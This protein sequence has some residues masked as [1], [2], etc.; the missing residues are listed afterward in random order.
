MAYGHNLPWRSAIRLGLRPH[1]PRQLPVAA[2]C[3]SS[4]ISLPQIS[5]ASTTTPRYCSLDTRILELR[6]GFAT[7]PLRLK[8]ERPPGEE[9][10]DIVEEEVDEEAKRKE[11]EEGEK[12]KKKKEK[13]EEKDGE[14]KVE[15]GKREGIPLPADVLKGAASSASGG[16]RSGNGGSKSSS[17][18][19]LLKPTVPDVYPQ[20]MALPIAGRPLFPGFYKAITIRDPKATAAIQEMLKRGQPYV[21]AFLFKDEEANADTISSTD[22]VYEIGVF[23]QVTSVFPV[24]GEEGAINAVLYP[25]RRIRL[26]GLHAQDAEDAE[27]P[28]EGVPDAP[29]PIPESYIEEI[30]EEYQE[31]KDKGD[32]VA[33]FEEPTEIE[34]PVKPISGGY[35]TGF[36]KKFGVSIV[37][38]ENVADEPFD[39][40]DPV[41]RAVTAEIVSVFKDV[42]NMNPLFRDQISNFSISQ[43]SGNVIDEPAKLADF[44]AAVAAG[45]VAEL[46]EVLETIPV[47]ER[48]QKALVVLKKE[49][50]NIQ[51]Q[52]KIS[53]D[54]EAKIHKRQR[55]YWLLE[56]MKGIK[57]ELGIESDGKEKLV[58]N[59]KAKAAKLAMPEQVKK[60]F[61]DVSRT[62]TPRDASA[63][64]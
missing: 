19:A 18:R 12:E 57:R 55:E 36:L 33:S 24:A 44:A 7:S 13:L 39:K 40:K 37:D 60:V 28:A 5:R 4:L 30:T 2:R 61:D 35:A 48:L 26:T 17:Q 34:E 31:R 38:V 15:S 8:E 42:A 56:Q 3:Y 41:V 9:E 46:Q 62:Q 50:M 63:D 22:E 10:K 43:S 53:K 32:V 29:V 27:V 49:L 47:A 25:H 58:E 52:S 21:A 14:G 6:R 54:V 64:G 59:F 45:E 1:A 11:V 20:V 23:A 16:G 51:L